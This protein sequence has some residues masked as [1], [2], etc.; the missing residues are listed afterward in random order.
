MQIQITGRISIQDALK[1][2]L[3]LVSIISLPDTLPGSEVQCLNCEVKSLSLTDN[4]NQAPADLPP[5]KIH[6]CV[7]ASHSSCPNAL[8]S[9]Y[10]ETRDL[11]LGVA[12]QSGSIWREISLKKQDGSRWARSY[13][14]DDISI[15]PDGTT[16]LAVE[17]TGRFAVIRERAACYH[18][19]SFQLP[20]YRQMDIGF[21][22][23]NEKDLLRRFR[24]P[25]S[26]RILTN[27]K[28]PYIAM[29]G[30][31]IK[32]FC[33][34]DQ[35]RF[36]A[37]SYEDGRIILFDTHT[38]CVQRTLRNSQWE[39]S[40]KTGSIE[41][42]IEEHGKTIPNAEI[43]LAE[44]GESVYL[45]PI[46]LYADH[47]L[48]FKKHYLANHLLDLKSG[49]EI[50]M[51]LKKGYTVPISQYE[52]AIIFQENQKTFCQWIDVRDLSSCKVFNADDLFKQNQIMENYRLNDRL[53]SRAGNIQLLI[54]KFSGS[55]F[56]YLSTVIHRGQQQKLPEL[57]LSKTGQD[58]L[59]EENV[60]AAVFGPCG[61]SIRYC[62]FPNI[63][64]LPLTRN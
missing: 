44:S 64:E 40:R 10:S 37:I 15:S 42:L 25:G 49:K 57:F 30:L 41:F 61:Q 43:T 13:S 11:L 6:N 53:L 28:Q 3:I 20:D 23:R 48:L 9:I 46:G 63:V 45:K 12:G 26:V 2:L 27:P 59:R 33:W 17:E 51:P 47:Y 19:W 31:E 54:S 38:M 34:L 16:L 7:I 8:I 55:D 39:W 14:I 24:F 58:L 56:Q 1:L 36:L 35:N 22:S 52:F 60:K 5:H 18:A 4:G 29:H 21:N 32:S 50:H 62:K